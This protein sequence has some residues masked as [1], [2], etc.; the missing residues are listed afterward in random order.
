[1]TAADVAA[2]AAQLN[3]VLAELIAEFQ[4]L[5]VAHPGIVYKRSIH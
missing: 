5:Q 3:E 4:D 2:F 1:M